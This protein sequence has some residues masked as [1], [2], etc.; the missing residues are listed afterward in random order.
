M[1]K[2]LSALCGALLWVVGGS[3]ANLP[4]LRWIP[5]DRLTIVNRAQEGGPVWQ[6]I[7]VDR[8]PTLTPTVRQ[9]YTYPT[10]MALR[11]RTDSPV[12]YARWTTS[13]D[14]GSV[15]TTLIAQKGLDLY[16][17]EGD[18]WQY[19]GTGRPKPKGSKQEWALME[20]A[21]NETR[22]CLLY[23]PLHDTIDS[24]QL[25]F[26][27][28]ATLAAAP[29]TFRGKVVC[30]GS[31]ITHGTGVSRPGMA[32]PARLQRALNMEFVNLGASGQCKLERFFADIV[33][34]TEADAF[35]FDTFSN[36]SPEQIAERF[37]EF[38]TTIRAAHPTTPLIFLQ[39]LDR[40]TT[41]YNQKIRAFEAGKQAAAREV[42]R[43]AMAT[44]PNIYFI[45]P[46]MPIGSDH[47]A[48]VDGVHPTDLGHERILRVIEP[49]LRTILH[50]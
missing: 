2:P 30:V 8:Y 12:L 15:N 39:T 37:D 33:A 34:D 14:P 32:Y 18:R 42:L 27:P 50:R 10:G 17:L 35:M 1:I 48:T 46:G 6:R 29:S 16:I 23:L 7:D 36:P 11:F 38:L 31:S 5:A 19:A 21:G 28:G 4:E 49:Q 20:H 22:E 3:A 43:K 25:G 41:S 47:E 44:D 24:L 45:N 26:K 9:Y 40:E 13:S